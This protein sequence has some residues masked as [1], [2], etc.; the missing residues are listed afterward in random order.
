MIDIIESSREKIEKICKD[1]G[2]SYLAVFGSH[3]RGTQ[4]SNSD[5]DLLVEFEK[6]PGLIDFIRTKNNLESVLNR[7]VDLVTKDGL[8]KYIKPHIQ[9]DLQVIYG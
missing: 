2:I 8:S 6:T 4:K 3:A 7:K 1:A 5:V 9:K